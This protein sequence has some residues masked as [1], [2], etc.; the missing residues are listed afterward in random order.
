[1]VRKKDKCEL[2]TFR[3]DA[4]FKKEKKTDPGR[5]HVI[6]FIIV[7]VNMSADTQ[8]C[9]VILSPI[10]SNFFDMFKVHCFNKNM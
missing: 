10:C 3:A 6:N 4:N 5:N 7:S 9:F 1:M 2:Y 8:T